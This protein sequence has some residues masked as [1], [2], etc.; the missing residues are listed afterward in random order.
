MFRL[1]NGSKFY[2][3]SKSLDGVDDLLDFCMTR[4]GDMNYLMGMEHK[5]GF[6]LILKGLEK[7]QKEKVYQKWL[8]DNARYE[9]SFED[10]YQSHL[11]Y[12]KT[13][14]KEKDEILAKWG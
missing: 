13:T 5:Q 11:P 14:Q 12:Q 2:K 3:A 10:Y 9:M 6:M 4:Y 8:S 7:A 1:Q